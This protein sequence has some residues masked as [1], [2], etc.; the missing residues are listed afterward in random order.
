MADGIPTRSSVWGKKVESSVGSPPIV[1]FTEVMSE[2]LAEQLQEQDLNEFDAEQEALMASLRDVDD[3]NDTSRDFELALMLSEDPDCSDDVKM[4]RE[5]Q[6]Q[7]DREADWQEQEQYD[8]KGKKTIV[9]STDSHEYSKLDDEEEFLIE[10]DEEHENRIDKK[11]RE[12]VQQFPPCGFV[13]TEDGKLLTKHDK[14]IAQR[15]N[16]Q[17]MMLFPSDFKSGDIMDARLSSKIYNDLSMFSKG[18]AKRKARV[19]DKEEKATSEA[20]IDLKTRIIILKFINANHIDRVEEIIAI[21]KESSVL[22]GILNAT[23]EN[24]EGPSGVEAHDE[25]HFAI[26]VYKQTLNAFRNRAEYVKDDF[27]FKNPRSVLRIWAIKEMMNLQRLR[28]ADLPCPMPIHL[29]KHVLLMSLIGNDGPAPKLK[30]MKWESE[31][32][33]AD[34]FQQTKNIMVRMFKDCRLVHSDFSEFNLLFADGVVHVID[35]AQAV[36]ISHPR[37][38]VYLARDIENILDFFGKMMGSLPTK[39]DLF[40]DVTDIRLEP[41]NNLVAQVEAFER[42]NPTNLTMFR[43]RTADYER[44]LAERDESENKL[45]GLEDSDSEEE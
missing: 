10:E 40:Y 8:A 19:K 33:K 16:C 29:K 30:D 45:V 12:K 1:S 11:Y 38:L 23:T 22:H 41:E 42:E 43:K 3:E 15:R 37:A 39:Q 18:E 25:K 36:D 20:C 31:E 26:K 2:T 34:V 4:A 35:V 44:M 6:L 14:E 21:G 13:R 27:R 17:K 24:E 7:F 5:L 28:R 32:Q 9:L